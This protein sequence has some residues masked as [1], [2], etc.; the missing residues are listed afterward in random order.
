MLNLASFAIYKLSRSGSA[1]AMSY[2]RCTLRPMLPSRPEG[3]PELQFPP[4]RRNQRSASAYGAT[5]WL[6]DHAPG[7]HS[8]HYAPGTQLLGLRV[9]WRQYHPGISIWESPVDNQEFPPPTGRSKKIARL[10]S[11]VKVCNSL[12]GTNF[13]Y[14]DTA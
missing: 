9:I 6:G 14:G 10:N 11:G 1:R 8:L 4:R 7:D 12:F 13:A 5:L 2:P 3:M